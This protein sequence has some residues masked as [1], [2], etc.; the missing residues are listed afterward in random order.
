MIPVT[1]TYFPDFD[2]YVKKIETI[3]QKGWLTNNGSLINELV[4]ELKEYLGLSHLELTANGTLALQ[5]AIKALEIKGEIITTPYSYVATTTSIL[6]EGCTPVFVD[7]E[8]NTFTINADLIEE[9]ITKT[10]RAILATHVYGYPCDVIKIEKIAKK[11]N[12][13]VIYDAA[14]CFGIKLNGQS[15]LLH[16]DCSI[17]SFHATK[18]FHTAE[19]GAVIC[20]NT[21]TAQRIA[22]MKKF[23]HHGEDEYLDIGINAKMSELHAAMGLC[24]LPK[25]NDIIS[26]RK[27][28]SG[29]YD[30][31]LEN[32]D[33]QR[34]TSAVE[35]DYN[36]GYYPVVFSSHEVMM[37]VRQTLIDNG[38]GPRR[39]FYP[40]LNTLPFLKPE[41]KKSCPISE[42]IASRV[43]CLPLYVS[44]DQNDVDIICK[45]IKR[46]MLNGVRL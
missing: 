10:T 20:K 5:L 11:Y 44:L 34:P 31:Q 27:E 26:A 46:S 33:I 35:L 18:L 16:G 24:V 4:V 19:G 15:I 2:D 13:K 3:W 12:L 36:Y 43:L 42:G 23:G 17:I 38:V 39:Y 22:L 14:H 1:K 37:K 8:D 25:V 28:Y 30:E 40:S 6:W 45:I 9:A 21:G 32:C 7:I 29:W 41:L